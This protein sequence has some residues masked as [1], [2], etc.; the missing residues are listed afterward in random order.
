MRMKQIAALA[1]A[2]ISA[3]AICGWAANTNATPN[4]PVEVV[5]AYEKANLAGGDWRAY[6]SKRW[7]AAITPAVMNEINFFYVTGPLARQRN[8]LAKNPPKDKN[9]IRGPIDGINTAPL[10]LDDVKLVSSDANTA[11]VDCYLSM[12]VPDE[13]RNITSR[14]YLI[15]EDGRWAVDTI[16]ANMRPVWAMDADRKPI[17]DQV[18]PIIQQYFDAQFDAEGKPKTDPSAMVTFAK[19]NL[20]SVSL[21]AIGVDQYVKKNWRLN[22]L[23]KAKLDRY[24]ASTRLVRPVA[25]DVGKAPEAGQDDIREV[26]YVRVSRFQNDSG[27]NEA[28]IGHGRLH[29]VKE[30]GHWKLLEPVSA[31]DVMSRF[32]ELLRV[33]NTVAMEKMLAPKATFELDKG[34]P[35]GWAEAFGKLPWLSVD[36]SPDDAIWTGK[37]PSS[38]IFLASIKPLGSES[39]WKSG[40]YEFETTES[41]KTWTITSIRYA[42]SDMEAAKKSIMSKLP[43]R[44]SPPKP[45][46]KPMRVFSGKLTPPPASLPLELREKGNKGGIYFDDILLKNNGKAVFFEDFQGDLSRWPRKDNAG[47]ETSNSKAACLYLNNVVSEAFHEA[48]ITQPGLIELSAWVW[49]PPATEQVRRTFTD[50]NLY[51]GTSCDNIGA[52]VQVDEKAKGYCIRLQWNRSDG[53][54]KEVV[55]QSSVLQPGKWARLALHLDSKTQQASALLDGVPQVSFHYAPANFKTIDCLSAWGSLGDAKMGK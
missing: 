29:F 36:W 6:L 37:T 34:K 39:P 42:G 16:S 17:Y 26:F 47:V 13:K 3:L 10:D 20:A 41:D 27:D 8:E 44:T 18:E 9:V 52:G 32:I 4:D 31:G 21:E 43:K 30:D 24:L 55:T 38:Q 2:T 45:P 54:D 33:K 46:A 1:L 15:K 35:M 11:V 40:V 7:Q 51:S 28:G 48:S 19:N 22:N 14:E 50:L 49:L 12:N 25:V 5:R 23:P 53:D